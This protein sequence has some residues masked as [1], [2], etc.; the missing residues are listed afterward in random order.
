ML[1]VVNKQHL[2]FKKLKEGVNREQ[3]NYAFVGMI[4]LTYTLQLTYNYRMGFGSLFP[5]CYFPF[6]FGFF[7]IFFKRE[8]KIGI[9]CDPIATRWLEPSHLSQLLL[10]VAATL[11]DNEPS[12]PE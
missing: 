3:I 2:D 7:F 1:E 5:F 6:H 10:V 4:L 8:E 9:G 11:I 12:A